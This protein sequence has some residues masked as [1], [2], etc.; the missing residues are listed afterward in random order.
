MFPSCSRLFVPWVL[1]TKSSGR[2][3]KKNTHD[4]NSFVSIN[5]WGHV[6][7]TN[8]GGHVYLILVDL[9]PQPFYVL[10]RLANLRCQSSRVSH[11]RVFFID[12]FHLPQGLA[13]GRREWL[14]VLDPCR[15]RG[16]VNNSNTGM[17]NMNI[18]ATLPPAVLTK[19]VINTQD[20]THTPLIY[21]L[22]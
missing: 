2:L 17:H 20:T 16:W 8:T 5:K 13:E 7:E 15:A 11:L 18:P 4:S 10:W 3:W 14:W 21:F 19:M 6:T 1:K 12:I 9:S 22:L